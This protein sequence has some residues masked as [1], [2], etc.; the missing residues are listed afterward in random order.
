MARIIPVAHT[1]VISYSS[2]V[3][4]VDSQLQWWSQSSY[5][6]CGVN[7]DIFLKWRSQSILIEM[8]VSHSYSIN[9]FVSVAPNIQ[10]HIV[11]S[12]HV[13]NS[14]VDCGIVQRHIEETKLQ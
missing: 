3:T 12:S 9:D 6:H 10:Y 13:C 1:G 8:H 11:L 2:R 4:G 5:I 14:L 7:F